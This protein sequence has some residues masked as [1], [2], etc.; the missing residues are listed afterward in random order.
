VTVIRA[1]RV[2]D[3]AAITDI[4]RHY[5]RHSV[6]TF[7]ETPWS[8]KDW[9]EKFASIAERELPFIVAETGGQVVGYAYT[10][11]WRP[12]P[13]GLTRCCSSAN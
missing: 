1:A 6:A 3:L 10:T 13:A 5:V 8:V 4:Y 12:K 2:A 9:E 11:P 7:E